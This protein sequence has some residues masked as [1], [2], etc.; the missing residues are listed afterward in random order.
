LVASTREV[1]TKV[2][3]QSGKAQKIQVSHRESEGIVKSSS[4]T[5][6]GMVA[7]VVIV[8]IVAPLAASG[9]KPCSALTLKGAYGFTV[10]GSNSHINSTFATAGRFLADGRG[11]ISGSSVQLADE[12]I[13]HS[14]FSGTYQVGSDCTGVAALQFDDARTSRLMFTIVSNGN[15]VF[16]VVAG[17][18]M[19]ETGTAR[20]Q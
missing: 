4:I 3:G 15:E 8:S 7:G 20:L 16:I 11:K 17:E 10:A 13:L 2:Q 19:V 14:T 6:W 12:N 1:G 9:L 5:T 18:G